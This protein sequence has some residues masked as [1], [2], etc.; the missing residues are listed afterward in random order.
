MT[1]TQGERSYT[2]A[3]EEEDENEK[4][5]EEKA[6]EAEAEKEHI[7]RVVV[8]KLSVGSST[9]KKAWYRIPFHRAELSV[10]IILPT[11]S[12]TVLLQIDHRISRT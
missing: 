5:E 3:E 6:E 10:S 4:E 7:G 11:D 8:L 2:R 1:Y 9:E 12:Q